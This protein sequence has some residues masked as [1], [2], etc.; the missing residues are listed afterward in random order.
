MLPVYN[1]FLF[2][3]PYHDLSHTVGEGLHD[4][5]QGFAVIAEEGHLEGSGGAAAVPLAVLGLLLCVIN[6]LAAA[7]PHLK[8]FG[9]MFQLRYQ[10]R[11]F[12]QF[13]IH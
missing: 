4:G 10:N 11:S 2:G 3:R 6:L 8:N 1:N 9:V 12:A 7:V 13:L 5:D